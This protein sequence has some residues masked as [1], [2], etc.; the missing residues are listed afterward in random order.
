MC[1]KGGVEEELLEKVN[2]VVE[3]CFNSN[4]NRKCLANYKLIFHK[5]VSS[6]L[7][8][9][10]ANERTSDVMIKGESQDLI[11]CNYGSWWFLV[12]LAFCA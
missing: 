7:H 10:A 5:A 3:P 2:C 1:T 11:T 4:G 12:N 6:A 9:A 8:P